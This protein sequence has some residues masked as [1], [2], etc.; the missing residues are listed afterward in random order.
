VY[1]RTIGWLGYQNP[2]T[3]K[4]VARITPP[5]PNT[6]AVYNAIKDAAVNKKLRLAEIKL[7]E[8]ASEGAL[9]AF[10][11]AEDFADA[12]NAIMTMPSK[13]KRQIPSEDTD[14]D[15]SE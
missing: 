1:L 5:T 13:R 11:S 7:R 2:F 14:G 9:G 12:R 15:E 6:I 4:I 10:D 3:G 8:L